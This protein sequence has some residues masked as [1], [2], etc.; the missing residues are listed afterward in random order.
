M[1]SRT[2]SPRDY[3]VGYRKPPVHTRFRKGVSGNPG[4]RPRKVAGER[5]KALALKEAYRA[6]TIK[7]GGGTVKVPAVQAVLRRQFAV[8]AKGSA[9]AQRAV[10]AAIAAIENERTKAAAERTAAKA[11]STPMSD[12]EAIRRICF[13]LDLPERE[14]QEK[15]RLEE[16]E[17]ARAA[18]AEMEA[19]IAGAG[20]ARPPS[21][22]VPG[23][24]SD[25]GKAVARAPK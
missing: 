21:N 3:D 24:S 8:A 17:K 23:A 20:V 15:E 19:A 14:Q 22:D 25:S 11:E 13:L 4:G 16:E 18:L 7:E 1:T 9:L 2:K 6:V 5:V 12:I 10:F